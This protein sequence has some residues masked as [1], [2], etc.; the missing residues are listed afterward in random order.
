MGFFLK[1]LSQSKGTAADKKTTFFTL[2]SIS[3]SN[4]SMSQS[5]PSD[6][7]AR[8]I[9]MKQ[10]TL[11]IRNFS[12]RTTEPT[13]S[14][15]S[16]QCSNNNEDH[17]AVKIQSNSSPDALTVRS[18][19]NS[20]TRPP[21]NPTTKISIAPSRSG[22]SAMSRSSKKSLKKSRSS[23]KK[24]KKASSSCDEI[25][26]EGVGEDHKD[27]VPK[28]IEKKPTSEFKPIEE[29]VYRVKL[30]KDM[31][32]LADAI[33]LDNNT[34]TLLASYDAKTIEDFFMM[35]ETDFQHLLAK[36]RN[37]NRGLPP[38]QIR[39]VRVLREWITELIEKTHPDNSGM[40]LPW[41]STIKEKKNQNAT[42]DS[43]LP[44]DWKRQ[45][46]NDLPTLKKKLR[47]K[48]DSFAEIFPWLS[49]IFGFRD[50]LCGGG[51]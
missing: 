41:E 30:E 10:G 8:S 16:S 11:K 26:P 12:S 3:T 9:S 20:I 5:L 19:N 14:D 47:R 7:D 32:L 6:E 25:V 39:K 46:Q 33:H 1:S 45:F 24:T 13:T 31:T 18:R 50:S 2:P 40:R 49:Y 27:E 35:G 17:D 34:R 22:I 37:T 51:Y 23:K 4:S 29:S 38:L 36:A 42:E 15:S 21:I 44:K 28:K 43:L 48:G